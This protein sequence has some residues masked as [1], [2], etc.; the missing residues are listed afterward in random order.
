MQETAYEKKREY[1][2]CAKAWYI[3]CCLFLPQNMCLSWC[4]SRSTYLSGMKNQRASSRRIC[5]TKD[6]YFLPSSSS[7]IL[8]C[9]Y[10]LQAPN[11]TVHIKQA[12]QWNAVLI[13]YGMLELAHLEAGCWPAVNNAGS[14]HLVGQDLLYT[15]PFVWPPQDC[16]WSNLMRELLFVST[17]HQRGRPWLCFSPYACAA[18]PP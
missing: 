9:H 5:R 16:D 12:V 17:P 15:K 18:V 1:N 3:N 14:T 13:C 6:S 10:P 11:C 8:K 4:S 7:S 2:I